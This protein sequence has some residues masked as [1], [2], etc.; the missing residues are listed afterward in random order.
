MYSG[1]PRGAW[2]LFTREV[3]RFLKVKV[4]TIVAPALTAIL[5]HGFKIG[6]GSF[7]LCCDMPNPS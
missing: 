4:Q 6:K 1:N 7:G 3:N 5:Y 2:T